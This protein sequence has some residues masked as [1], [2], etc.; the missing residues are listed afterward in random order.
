MRI[1]TNT[2]EHIVKNMVRLAIQTSGPS[3]Q[4]EK[5]M[6]TNTKHL[7]RVPTPSKRINRSDYAHVPQ[8]KN[9]RTVPLPS[10]PYEPDQSFSVSSLCSADVMLKAPPGMKRTKLSP[11]SGPIAYKPL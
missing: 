6:P 10:L 5:L 11:T 7:A 4:V 9:K 3:L 1:P 8:T 2:F